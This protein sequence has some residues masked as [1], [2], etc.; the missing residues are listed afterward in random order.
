MPHVF[1]FQARD[2]RTNEVVA[3][4]K[5]SYSGKQSNEVCRISRVLNLDLCKCLLC[6]M[7]LISFSY[8]KRDLPCNCKG[9]WGN[10]INKTNLFTVHSVYLSNLLLGNV[11]KAHCFQT[12]SAHL[13][14]H[15]VCLLC[16]Y[17]VLKKGVVVLP[18]D[19]Q[20]WIPFSLTI[21]ILLTVQKFIR[22][23]SN[24]CSS[25][26]FRENFAFNKV[27]RQ[28]ASFPEMTL[29]EELKQKQKATVNEWV[30]KSEQQHNQGRAV[31]A[32]D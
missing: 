8:S 27:V 4:K 13:Q 9:E 28:N 23:Y 14:G 21:T 31:R 7:I 10:C 12:W 17:S 18:L 25:E 5:M 20:F 6:G 15:I 24:G 1:V 22:N 2:V 30:W 11:S 3:I 16:L 32:G 26:R 19:I 29:E